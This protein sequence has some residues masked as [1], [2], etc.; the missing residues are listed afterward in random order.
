MTESCVAVRTAWTGL[1][2]AIGLLLLADALQSNPLVRPWVALTCLVV[3]LFL[4]LPSLLILIASFREVEV[5]A[6]SML[7]YDAAILVLLFLAAL[8]VNSLTAALWFGGI[9]AVVGGLLTVEVAQARQELAHDQDAW[10]R[11]THYWAAGLITV[12]LVALIRVHP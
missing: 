12:W 2:G 7:L 9:V 4:F 6:R 5:A 10:K 8:L 11:A 3:W 1:I